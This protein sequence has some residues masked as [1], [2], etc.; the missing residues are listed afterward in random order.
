MKR[1]TIW[2]TAMELCRCSDVSERLWRG[3]GNASADEFRKD[4]KDYFDDSSDD[5]VHCILLSPRRIV[6][7]LIPKFMVLYWGV[8]SEPPML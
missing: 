7:F 2:I 4:R 5:L 6:S 3:E 8:D 1:C